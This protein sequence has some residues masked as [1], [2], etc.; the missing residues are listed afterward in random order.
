MRIARSFWRWFDS[1][2]IAYLPVNGPE[3]YRIDWLRT[4]PFIILH[5]AVVL[6]VWV[7]VSPIAVFV[8]VALYVLRM[9]AV[10]GG[11][12]LLVW[13]FVISTLAV[14]HAT[15][16]VNSVGHLIGR[17]RYANRDDSINSWWLALLT[18]GEGWH[19]NHHRFPGAVRQGVR[20]WEIDVTYYGLR[21]LA[22]LRLI[23]GLK[24]IPL[25]IAAGGRVS[26]IKA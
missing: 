11:A 10:T 19:N 13:G 20:W 7:G 6:V 22:A 1:H 26:E 4:I 23:S 18:F 15:F 24:T 17:H 9:F 14:Y 21:M 25:A 3:S 16:R 5:V 12:Q 8:A 2:A